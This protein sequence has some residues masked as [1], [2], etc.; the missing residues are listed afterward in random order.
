LAGIELG[1][2]EEYWFTG[3]GGDR[4][5]GFLYYPA[6]YD[7][8]KTYPLVQLLHGGPHTMNR[9]AWNYRWNAHALAAPGYVVTWINR[10][11]STGFGEKFSQSILG[12]WGDKPLEDILNS[13]DFLL[14]KLP[15][16]DPK[17]MAAAGGSYGGYMAAWVAGHTDRFAALI[18]HAGVNDFITQFGAD[19]TS[20]GFSNVLGGRPWETPRVCSATTP[21]RTRATFAHR[22]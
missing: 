16:L 9:D 19:I 14:A 8:A 3:A 15:N 4:V 22:C 10:H 5:H 6:G 21:R 20:F 18:N 13:T 12:Q 7:P 2:V 1:R 11:G 17:R